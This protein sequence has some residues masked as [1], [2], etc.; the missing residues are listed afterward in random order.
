M[1]LT[2]SRTAVA[3]DPAP[4]RHLIPCVPVV[5]FRRSCYGH[6]CTVRE[7]GFVI[8]R[9]PVGFGLYIR[10]V[11]NRYAEV[12]LFDFI[13]VGLSALLTY[14]ERIVAMRTLL[15]TADG[16]SARNRQFS[17]LVSVLCNGFYIIFVG[18]RRKIIENQIIVYGCTDVEGRCIRRVGS[19]LATY[20]FPGGIQDRAGY[21]GNRA[22]VRSDRAA[23]TEIAALF[24][25]AGGRYLTT[26]GR[27]R[28][29]VVNF[30]TEG[31]APVTA[32][33]VAVRHLIPSVSVVVLCCCRN[34]HRCTS[35][36][37]GL[38]IC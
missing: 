30:L 10:L 25:S 31:F 27:S 18:A 17:R 9:V 28:L 13:G 1:F 19:A 12:C 37:G 3:A 38:V 35:R 29:F 36:K 24:Q 23:Q 5:V 21:T 32:Y 11:N 22:A 14:T 4:V 34:S 15:R 8:R 16:K 7:C 20:R 33:P 26:D 2:D 6:L